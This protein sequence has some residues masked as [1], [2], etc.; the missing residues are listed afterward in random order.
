MVCMHIAA[1]KAAYSGVPPQ[2]FSMCITDWLWWIITP[3]NQSLNEFSN[4]LTIVYDLDTR[5]ASWRRLVYND[6]DEWMDTNLLI[7]N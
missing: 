7:S 2:F 4:L 6:E 3:N 5:M 1:S